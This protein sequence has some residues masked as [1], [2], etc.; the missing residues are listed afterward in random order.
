M[1]GRYLRRFRSHGAENF[2]PGFDGWGSEATVKDYGVAVAIPQECGQV[3]DPSIGQ[4]LLNTACQEERTGEPG[5][6]SH[7]LP[8]PRLDHVAETPRLNPAVVRMRCTV[9]GAIPSR[10]AS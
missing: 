5:L 6:P 8:P 10:V 1:A 3:P 7:P 2:G 4:Y 9:D